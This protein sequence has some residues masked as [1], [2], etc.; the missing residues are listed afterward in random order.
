MV[1]DEVWHTSR[2]GGGVLCLSLLKFDALMH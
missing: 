2:G 1:S